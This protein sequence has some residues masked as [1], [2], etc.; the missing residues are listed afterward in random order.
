LHAAV[1]GV[2]QPDASQVDP[3]NSIFNLE[4]QKTRSV[5]ALRVFMVAVGV[6]PLAIRK[7]FYRSAVTP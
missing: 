4:T 1:D 2:N 5:T 3:T 6:E 7:S